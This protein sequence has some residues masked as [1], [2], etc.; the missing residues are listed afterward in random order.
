MGCKD[1]YVLRM[2]AVSKL[3]KSFQIIIYRSSIIVDILI[4][5]IIWHLV[6]GSPVYC[7]GQLH[8][9]LWLTTWQMAPMPHVPGQG[10]TH[11]W[12]MQAWFRGHSELTTH[13]G[14]HVG[15]LP[16]NPGTHEHTAC[17]FISRHWLLGPQ[18]D[19]LH[20]W[21]STGTKILLN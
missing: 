18:G 11:F 15:G 16:I 8:I 14:L 1:P 4:L 21:I 5:L 7:G 3:K 2:V 19:G 6:N 12:L 9:G 17:P 10:S 20:G 13:S